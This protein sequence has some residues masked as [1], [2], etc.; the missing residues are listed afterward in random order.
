MLELAHGGLKRRARLDRK[1][2]DETKALGP[3]IDTIEEGR[4]PAD[5]LL[6]AFDGPWRGDIDKLF[7][8]SAF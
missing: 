6:A 7:E 3:L 1:G 2:E 8:S 5:R 4:S